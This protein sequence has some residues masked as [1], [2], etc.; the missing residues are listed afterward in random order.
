MD[1]LLTATIYKIAVK[2]IVKVGGKLQM[3]AQCLHCTLIE[4][5]ANLIIGI[6][7]II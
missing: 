2:A 6:H 5:F 3:N 7:E 4:M 1:N